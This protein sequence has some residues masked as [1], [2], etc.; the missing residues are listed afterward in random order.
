MI[1]AQL[2]L[3][4]IVQASFYFMIAVGFILIFSVTK[5]FHMTHGL[6]YA[7]GAYLTYAFLGVFGLDPILGILLAFVLTTLAGLLCEVAFYRPLRKRNAASFI[8]MLSSFALLSLG[9]NVLAAL[10]TSQTKSVTFGHY[11]TLYEFFGLSITNINLLFIIIAVLSFI[12]LSLLLK[13]TKLGKN[14]RAVGDNPL[15]AD[16]IGVS[17][18]KI[19]N[20]VFIIGSAF[21]ALAG[22][23]SVINIG[24]TPEMGWNGLLMSMVI[25]IVGGIGSIPGAVIGALIVGIVTNFAVWLVPGVWLPAIIFGILL[26]CIIV[27]PRGILG[28]KTGYEI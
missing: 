27:R 7:L 28:V 4:G 2:L 25:A 24:A 9:V 1:Y 11:Q 18:N 14:I 10:T 23:V 26:I 17:S 12:G 19:F 3:N 21:A 8:I 5:T 6:I 20:W 16:L 22:I 13:K 15:M